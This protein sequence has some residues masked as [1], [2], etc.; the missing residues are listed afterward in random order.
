VREVGGVH[1]ADESDVIDLA[2]QVR[3]GI[4]HPHAALAMLSEL[5]RAAHQCA[6]AT[7]VL[8]FAGD[9]AEVRVA[10]VLVEHRLRIEQVHLAGAAVHEQMD[11]RFG[12][13]RE[14]R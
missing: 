9:L 8:D 5:E 2:G 1:R 3:H 10:V 11:D 7:R 14:V 13:R 6:G 4:G 12:L